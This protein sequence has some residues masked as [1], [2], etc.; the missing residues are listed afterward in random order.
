MLYY[1]QQTPNN[2]TLVKH[3]ESLKS[4]YFF[5]TVLNTVML[6]QVLVSLFCFTQSY[7][8]LL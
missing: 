1:A 2:G 4:L 5:N 3:K 8:S 6:T 7:V